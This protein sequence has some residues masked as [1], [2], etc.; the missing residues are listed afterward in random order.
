MKKIEFSDA[1]LLSRMHCESFETGWSK[2]EFEEMLSTGDYFGFICKEGFIV[3]RKILDEVE[4]F[5]IAV[6]PPFRSRGIGTTLIKKFHEEAKK[7]GSK[8]IFLEV[9]EDNI[10]A[11]KLYL[12]N[13]YEVINNRHNYYGKQDAII[14][15]FKLI[16]Y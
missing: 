11:K 2:N 9:R 8:V 16:K 10:F 14:M 15:Q 3:G 12:S 13:G 5:A 7:N 4:I 1:P 6:S